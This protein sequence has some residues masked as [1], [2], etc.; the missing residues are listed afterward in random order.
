MNRNYVTTND[1]NLYKRNVNSNL[2]GMNTQFKNVNLYETNKNL[3]TSE[4]LKKYNVIEN[5]GL[6]SELINRPYKLVLSHGFDSADNGE[7]T[8]ELNKPLKDVVS[9]KLQKA[10]ISGRTSSNLSGIDYFIL[11]IDELSKNYSDNT[12]NKFA[13]S[14]AILD[15]HMVADNSGSG[16]D[17]KNYYKNVFN[18]NGD[19][20]YFDPPKN[21]LA[22]L[23]VKL[24]KDD[25]SL[26]D[27]TLTLRLELLIE[28][29]EKLKVY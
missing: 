2:V 11:H 6:K 4:T 10:F 16:S 15:N 21:V 20:E 17:S 23:N 28:T 1:K 27:K 3:I 13:G 19:I 29:K 22:R 9:V 5:K 8:F 26:N 25:D 24:F 14:F 18:E 7:H 12:P